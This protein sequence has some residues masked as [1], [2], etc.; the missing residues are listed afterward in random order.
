M[1]KEFNGGEGPRFGDLDTVEKRQKL[2][3]DEREV[4]FE[5][6]PLKVKDLNPPEK[7][8]Y[9]FLVANEG[10]TFTSQLLAEKLGST[11][12]KVARSIQRV[13][14]VIG[15]FRNQATTELP[16]TYGYKTTKKKK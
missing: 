2:Y 4:S 13:L 3:A 16:S 6:P 15:V 10:V 11:R 1:P 12:N 9:D 7:A 8:I 5:E 14:R